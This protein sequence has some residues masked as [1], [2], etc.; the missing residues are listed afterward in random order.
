MVGE[1]LELVRNR[2]AVRLG[3]LRE[4]VGKRLARDVH[5]QERR[6]DPCL[7]VRS[8]LRLESQR[9]ER[10]VAHRL[11]AQRI[12]PG[13]EMAVRAMCLHERHC[14]R[15]PAEELRRPARRTQAAQP[16]GAPR[17]RQRRCYSP[18]SGGASRAA[19]QCPG[20]SRPARSRRSRRARATRTAPPPGSRGTRRA[21]RARSRR[22][23]RRR[24][25]S[26]SL[27]CT[28]VGARRLRTADGA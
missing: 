1:M 12:E 20:A 4:H 13:S 18:R 10:R 8:Q 2:P 15:D 17:L 7:E 28:R 11:R 22:S 25:A 9:L 3:E 19:G 26:S 27:C 21:G 5:T 24:H 23:G 14:R 6:R 16:A